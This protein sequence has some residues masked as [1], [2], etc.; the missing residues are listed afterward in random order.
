MERTVTVLG[1]GQESVKPELAASGWPI[2][3]P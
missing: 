1:E 3:L 2:S